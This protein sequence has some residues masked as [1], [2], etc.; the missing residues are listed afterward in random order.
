M[1][2]VK[3]VFSRVKSHN[4][5]IKVW[6]MFLLLIPYLIIGAI[7]DVS[8]WMWRKTGL[9]IDWFHKIVQRKT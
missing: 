5:K 6:L 8:Y 9:A 2:S 1:G 7:H 4:K 3:N